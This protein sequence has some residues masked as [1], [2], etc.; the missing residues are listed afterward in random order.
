MTKMTA[1][2][3][4]TV[5]TTVALP[6]FPMP[7]LLA[8]PG[9]CATNACQNIGAKIVSHVNAAYMANAMRDLQAMAAAPATRAGKETIVQQ[10]AIVRK[11]LAVWTGKI[12]I[13]ALKTTMGTIANHVIASM[14]IAGMANPAT[15]SVKQPP[16]Q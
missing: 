15:G 7:V 9:I 13:T 12:V 11:A 1:V 5:K 10:K 3:K 14:V 8:L 2:P 4:N 6:I 16:V